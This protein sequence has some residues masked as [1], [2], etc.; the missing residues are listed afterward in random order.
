MKNPSVVPESIQN[1]V[2]ILRCRGVELTA[3]DRQEL[4]RSEMAF[5]HVFHRIHRIEWK[6]IGR[7]R[8]VELRCEIQ[9]LSGKFTA[10]AIEENGRAALQSVTQKILK[11]K[12]RAKTISVTR[13]R[14]APA[15][16]GRAA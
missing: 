16:R 10:V 6:F 7:P 13:R 1:S 4:H 2:V 11:Q 3:A 14:A 12:R 5:G 15:H 8:E 9:A